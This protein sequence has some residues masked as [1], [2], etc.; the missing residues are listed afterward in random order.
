MNSAIRL[1]LTQSVLTGMIFVSCAV[2]QPIQLPARVS[3]AAKF[4][5]GLS[6]G[7]TTAPPSEPAVKRGNYATVINIHNP[8]ATDVSIMKKVALAAPERFPNT[9]LVPP[10]KRFQ[11]RLPSDHAMS[12]DCQEIVN[13]LTLNG[14][15]P[16]GTFIEGYLVIDSFFPTGATGS[17]DLDVVAVTSTAPS[18]TTSVNSH[19]IVTVPGRRLPAGTWPF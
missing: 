4:L 18:T 6:Q 1:A 9:A 17:A 13:L 10:T 2:A 8:W 7:A 15:P 16:A 5:C 11:D 12:V 14:T 19:E 3:Y